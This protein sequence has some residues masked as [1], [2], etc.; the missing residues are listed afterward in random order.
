MAEITGSNWGTPELGD[1]GGVVTWSFAGAGLDISSFG[2]SSGDS[3]DG[4]SFLTFNYEDVVRDAFAQWSTFGNIEFMQ[5]EDGGGDAG[6]G[7]VADIRIFFGAIPGGTIGYAFYPSS[8]GS[9]IAGDVLLDTVTSFNTNQNL[10]AAVVIHELGHALGLG[11]EDENSVMT[12]TVSESTLQQDDING[13][14][15]IYGVQDNA[16][17]VYDIPTGQAAL[18]ILDVAAGAT[19][20]GNDL[21][22]V[23]TGTDVGETINGANGN[24]TLFGEGGNDVIDGGNGRDQ[25]FLG[26]GDDFYQDNAE[27][28]DA[29]RDTVYGGTGKDTIQGGAGDDEFYGN[30]HEDLIFGDLGDDLI[31]GGDQSDTLNGGEGND[32]I[33]GGN[34]RDLANLGEGNDLFYDNGQ[35]GDFG[36]DTVFANNGNDTIQGGNGDDTFYGQWGNDLIFGRLGDDFLS[37][38]AHRDTIHGGDGN[39]TIDGG[40]GR[41]R[42]FMGDGDDVFQDNQ[43]SGQYGQDTVFGGAG[44][45]TFLA[46]AGDDI[47]TGNS[48]A[49]TFAFNVG[50]G[51]DVITD[52]VIGTDELRLDDALWSGDLSA[53]QVIDTYAMLLNGDVVLEF[54]LDTL[55]FEGLTS[56]AGLAD[57]LSIV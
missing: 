47:Y 17:V 15:E 5:I 40:H 2:D 37:G 7:T 1:A 12:A 14:Q 38:G 9:A 11:H 56:T 6:S 57:D 35:G 3:V 27:G 43:Q 48:G 8:Y 36:Q 34:G 19:I 49:D 39:D 4:D 13:I 10:F 20:N 22:N 28:G 44:N 24:D 26:D 16:A 29:G 31:S 52:F 30:Q 55:T 51:R 50:L 54:G 53:T 25:A 23:I 42:V 33:Y 41:D 45:D 32:T 46:G 21:D 18:T